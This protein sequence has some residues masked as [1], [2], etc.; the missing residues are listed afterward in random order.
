MPLRLD[1]F[2]LRMTFFCHLFLDPFFVFN[3]FPFLYWSKVRDEE[4]CMNSPISLMV[5]IFCHTRVKFFFCFYI[6]WR[7][8][9]TL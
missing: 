5:S 8:N 3:V 9:S 7:V 4:K 6:V 2:M 1:K